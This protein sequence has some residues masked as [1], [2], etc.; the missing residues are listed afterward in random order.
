MIMETLFIFFFLAS[1]AG[2]VA[3]YFK[4]RIEETIAPSI[5]LII[6]ILYIC[7]L[8]T[9]KLTSGIYCTLLLGM[10]AI[11][12][13][14]KEMARNKDEIVKW[15][16]TP[17]LFAYFILFGWIWWINRYRLFSSWDEFSHWGL[18]VKNMAFFDAF[19]NCP[20]STVTFRGYPPAMALWQ[21]FVIKIHG[22]FY[23]GY[24][25]QAMGW[26]ITALFLPLVSSVDWKHWKYAFGKLFCFLLLPFIFNSS[27][28]VLLYVDTILG[29]FYAYIVINSY[30]E[31]RFDGFFWISNSFA[32]IILCLTK[33]SGVF[34][35]CI[36]GG[37]LCFQIF[38]IKLFSLKR[39]CFC[40]GLCMASVL[41]GKV[42]WS[43]YL[44]LSETSSA[45]NTSSISGPNLLSLFSGKG[46]E[47]QYTVINVFLKRLSDASF[48]SYVFDMRV[49]TWIS[50][51]GLLFF[52]LLKLYWT[53][54]RK[55][56]IYGIGIFVGMIIYTAGLLV[57][58]IF[59]YSE[60]EAVRLASFDRYMSTYFIAMLMIFTYMLFETVEANRSK[61]TGWLL[62][63]VLLCFNFFVPMSELF[64]VTLLNTERVEATK[65]TR[66][67]FEQF[68]SELKKV[69]ADNSAVRINVIAQN[70]N[71]WEYVNLMYLA[72]PIPCA[73]S[74]SVGQKYSEDDIYTKEC[75]SEE[76]LKLLED[77][78]VTYVYLHS[79]DEPFIQRFQEVFQDT[80]E[81]GKLYELKGTHGQK[82][83]VKVE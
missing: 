3:V 57:L 39:Q 74:W 76:W 36:A 12:Y 11:L 24:V 20:G 15:C 21:Y 8:V 6:L 5:F 75:A 25:Y 51:F 31:Q 62:G 26:L 43:V 45:W 52:M 53:E 64:N 23:E 78:G 13:L 10:I 48:A 49:L 63:F 33:A 42:S 79:I 61:N 60:Y 29:I 22:V 81:A 46:Q 80:I 55:I 14:L 54:N 56:K 16:L 73:G 68:E 30:R 2:A 71:G 19:G 38:R 7:G 50:V 37:I 82:Y 40:S 1:I 69:D 18:V 77:E 27:Y 58:Y 66:K 72:T 28:L 70:T 47:Y 9:G 67:T 34:L 83:L 4:R 44:K 59:T 17:G 65:Q 35:A 32:L 41:F